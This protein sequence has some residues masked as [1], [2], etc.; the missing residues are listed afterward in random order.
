MRK[1][2]ADGHATSGFRASDL[3][4]E[5][6]APV[7]DAS[8]EHALIEALQPLM[9][10][11]SYSI[12]RTG[13]DCAPMLFMSGSRGVPDTTRE[14]WRAYLAGPQSQDRTFWLDEPDD[15]TFVCH[16]TAQ[17]VAP[18]HRARVYE[19]HGMCERVSVVQRTGQ[20]LFALN[21]YRHQHQ[22][23]F[24]ERQVSD[25]KDMALPLLALVKKHIALTGRAPQPAGGR[26]EDWSARLRTLQPELTAREVEVCARL[27]LGMTQHGIA[28]ELGLSLPTVKTYRNRAFGRLGIH[29]RNQLF[30]LLLRT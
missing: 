20:S 2:C 25:F 19:A 17:E 30:A 1:S 27:L 16:I 22:R 4:A 29:F 15:G 3:L 12:Y 5:L 13:T 26:L 23:P 10:A 6:I 9:H 8:F 28:A 14:C 11:A 21:F 24:L 7:G 18:L